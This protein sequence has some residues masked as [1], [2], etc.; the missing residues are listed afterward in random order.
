MDIPT[1]RRMETMKKLA[2]YLAPRLHPSEMGETLR[3]IEDYV[4]ASVE[5]YSYF[6]I[7]TSNE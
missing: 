5:E 1:T 4:D 7:A 2:H 3:L 6:V